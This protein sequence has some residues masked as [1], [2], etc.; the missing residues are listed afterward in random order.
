MVF[1]SDQPRDQ[2]ARR[3]TELFSSRGYAAVTVQDIVAA[4]GVTKPTLYHHFG[5]KLGLLRVVLQEL[6]AAFAVRISAAAT[7]RR[8]NLAQTLIAV[9]TAYFDHADEEPAFHR[10]LM[11]LWFG[12]PDSEERGVAIGHFELQHALFVQLFTAAADEH[13]N[14]RGR[15]E[16]YAATF[17]GMVHTYIGLRLNGHA[18]LDR[19]LTQRAVHQFMH[20]ILS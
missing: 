2:L 6:F 4:A 19:K 7:Y 13:G 8:G 18:R 9:A 12:P 1:D 14:M 11:L 15:H 10:L 16:A 20:G 5:S 3:A 17:L